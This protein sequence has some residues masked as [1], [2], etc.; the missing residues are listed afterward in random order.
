MLTRPRQNLL[1]RQ[2]W[3]PPH[4]QKDARTARQKKAWKNPMPA[5]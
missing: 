5:A 2:E 1:D 3:P 4:A